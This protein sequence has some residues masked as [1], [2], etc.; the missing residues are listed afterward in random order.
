MIYR[1]FS[2]KNRA[3]LSEMIRTDFKLR[4]Q[5]SVLGYLWSLLK[6]LMLFVILATLMLATRKVDWYAQAAGGQ[7]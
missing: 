6:P 5:N 7:A 2:K 1:V 3:L 4:Y